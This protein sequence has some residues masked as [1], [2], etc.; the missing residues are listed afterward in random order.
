MRC[1]RSTDPSSRGVHCCSHN[2]LWNCWSRCFADIW[3]GIILILLRCSRRRRQRSR[4][5]LLSLEL[6]LWIRLRPS[7]LWW[8]DRTRS[9]NWRSWRGRCNRSR[10]MLSMLALLHL[11]RLLCLW[12][13]WLKWTCRRVN[14]GRRSR[15]RV[16][17]LHSRGIRRAWRCRL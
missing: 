12:L 5:A 17:R 3:W 15:S 16:W 8:C 2:M 14:R 11:L 4:G 13:R 9:S 10:H 6:L 1:C 7:L